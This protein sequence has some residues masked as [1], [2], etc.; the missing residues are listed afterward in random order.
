VTYKAAATATGTPQII[1]S[2]N[3]EIKKQ[4]IIKHLN[5]ILFENVSN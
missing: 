3:P 4:L 2:D 1:Q 5:I